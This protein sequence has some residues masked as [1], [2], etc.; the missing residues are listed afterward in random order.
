MAC[1]YRLDPDPPQVVREI[2]MAIL[3]AEGMI[4]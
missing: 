1:D 2:G 4:R 3:E